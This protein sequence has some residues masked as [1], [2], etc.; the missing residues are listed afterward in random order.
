VE[1]QFVLK[2]SLNGKPLLV[3]DRLFSHVVFVFKLLT[4]TLVLASRI[5]L[6]YP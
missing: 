6:R 5:F 1:N 3:G 4:L 2:E